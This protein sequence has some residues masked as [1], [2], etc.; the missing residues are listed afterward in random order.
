MDS[1]CCWQELEAYRPAPQREF[2]RALRKAFWG[3]DALPGQAPGQKE[4]DTPTAEHEVWET[5]RVGAEVYAYF[6]TLNAAAAR[7][8]RFSEGVWQQRRSTPLQSMRVCCCDL[9]GIHHM[10]CWRITVVWCGPSATSTSPFPTS[11]SPA[12][13]TR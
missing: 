5:T 9:F 12:T 7:T 13:R 8:A 6:I 3:A 10:S 4:G 1:C 11:T 2:L